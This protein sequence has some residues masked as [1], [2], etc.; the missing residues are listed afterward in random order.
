MS[1]VYGKVTTFVSIA[2]DS[3][4]TRQDITQG[5]GCCGFVETFGFIGLGGDAP[6]SAHSEHLISCEVCS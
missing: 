2:L 4:K 1:K 3:G 6:E 5:F